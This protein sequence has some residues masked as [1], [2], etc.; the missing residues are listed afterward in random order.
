MGGGFG[1]CETRRRDETPG[2]SETMDGAKIYISRLLPRASV[3]FRGHLAA[4]VALGSELYLLP[5]IGILV[6]RWGNFGKLETEG[7]KTP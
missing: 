7:A 5:G 2:K 6:G 1:K 3:C 4:A